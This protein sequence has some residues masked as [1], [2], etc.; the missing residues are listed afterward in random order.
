MKYNQDQVIREMKDVSAEIK[1]ERKKYDKFLARD[2]ERVGYMTQ[3]LN[4]K[5]LVQLSYTNE[6]ARIKEKSH[7]NGL[8]TGKSSTAS[9]RDENGNKINKRKSV[10]KTRKQSKFGRG[11]TLFQSI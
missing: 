11:T 1:K 7:E 2:I 8:A 3:N 4:T 5:R 6:I 10:S 9:L